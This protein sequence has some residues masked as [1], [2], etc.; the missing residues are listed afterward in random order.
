M[1]PNC[2]SRVKYVKRFVV[3][4]LPPSPSFLSVLEICRLGGNSLIILTKESIIRNF[5]FSPFF[6]GDSRNKLNFSHTFTKQYVGLNWCARLR[7]SCLWTIYDFHSNQL[8]L[9]LPHHQTTSC[10]FLPSKNKKVKKLSRSFR[11]SVSWTSK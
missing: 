3:S 4:F 6:S 11:E 10:C 5:H 2:R 8:L 7:S 9:I 1:L